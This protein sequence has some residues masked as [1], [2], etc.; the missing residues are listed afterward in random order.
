MPRSFD[1]SADYQ[2]SVEDLHRTFAEPDYWRARLAD[3]P[4]DEAR[5][6]SIRVGG[7]PGDDGTIEVV[8]LQEVHSRNLPAMVTQL[9]RGDLFFRREE[10]WGPVT[11][12]IATASI[13]GTIVD[14]PVN[15]LGTAELSPID[16]G[17]ARLTF[18]VSI[19]VRIP[20]I[21]GKVENIIGTHLADLVSREQRFTTKW[22]T[23]NA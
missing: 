4:V 1:L 7:V 16:R 14:T 8:T 23:N 19:H 15:V 13:R 9:H 10:T 20:L 18:R 11:D 12:G 5:L 2:D 21:G 17:G 3:I 22:I 6:E